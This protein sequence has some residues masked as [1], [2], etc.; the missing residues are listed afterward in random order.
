MARVPQPGEK[1]CWEAAVAASSGIGD[2]AAL[3]TCRHPV[4]V[5]GSKAA[6]ETLGWGPAFHARGCE[7][8]GIHPAALVGAPLDRGGGLDALVRGL[9]AGLVPRSSTIVLDPGLARMLVENPETLERLSLSTAGCVLMPLEV[10]SAPYKVVYSDVFSF[11]EQDPSGISHWVWTERQG[12]AFCTIA[13]EGGPG[14]YDVAFTLTA[15]SPGSFTVRLGES[16]LRHTAAAENLSRRFDLLCYLVTGANTIEIDFDGPSTRPRSPHDQRTGIFY[17]IGDLLVADAQ[18]NSRPAHNCRGFACPTDEALRR[19]VHAAGFFEVDTVACSQHDL[20][21]QVGLRSCFD[22]RQEYRLRDYRRFGVPEDRP[23]HTP[24]D[25]PRCVWYRFAKTPHPGSEWS[26]YV[27]P[28]S[29]ESAIL[30]E[31]P[32]SPP[33]DNALAVCERHLT[34]VR[35]LLVERTGLLEKSNHALEDRSKELVDIRAALEERTGLLEKSNH[36]LED[37]SHELVLIRE[38][39]EERTRSLEESIMTLTEQLGAAYTLLTQ[40]T[41]ALKQ[42]VQDSD[43][44]AHILV[45]LKNMVNETLDGPIYGPPLFL[46]RRHLRTV[47]ESLVQVRTHLNNL[48]DKYS[49]PQPKSLQSGI[50]RQ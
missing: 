20:A 33:P 31:W 6:L 5:I 4:N 43:A 11:P 22:Y 10:A 3:I 49:H 47:T 26:G 39:L 21:W 46:A 25:L 13:H 18:T 29:L 36:A 17:C 1:H 50:A 12:R 15:A 41:A 42:A 30:A 2:V 34:E 24:A 38:L 7:I 37:R 14:E 8:H 32:S 44:T 16:V 40:R 45:A 27:P 28:R 9:A 23:I 19:L 35:L 48:T